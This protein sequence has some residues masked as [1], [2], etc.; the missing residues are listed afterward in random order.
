MFMLQSS[1]LYELL[2]F[3]VSHNT[4][5]TVFIYSIIFGRWRVTVL[6]NLCGTELSSS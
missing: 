4:T 1:I 3:L 6:K 5:I 2:G